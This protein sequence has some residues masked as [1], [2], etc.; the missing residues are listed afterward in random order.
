MNLP[1]LFQDKHLVAIN[2]PS[3][4]LVHRSAIDRHE[5]RFAVQTLRNQLS[6]HVYPIHRLDKPTS[7]VLLFAL[8][9]S[10]AHYLSKHWQ[11]VDKT[12]FALTRGKMSNAVVNH[13]I[14]TPPENKTPHRVNA[15]KI[16]AA[17]TAFKVQATATLP[18]TFGKRCDDFTQ[19][20]FSFV[21]AQPKTGRKHQI[22]KHLKHLNHPIIGD[23]RY[24]RGEINRYFRAQ[25][26]LSRLM[27][28]CAVLS[29]THPTDGRKLVIHAPL[30]STWQRLLGRLPW[31]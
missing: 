28:H 17:E 20:H 22:R 13:P 4:L 15:A 30:D 10:T 7:G 19:T 8:D 29:L 11:T 21:E 18:V 1:I 9:S 14:R 16:Q 25:F 24:G 31:Q 2:K 27:L 3:G 12:Y 5:T 26:G 6:Q 23:T